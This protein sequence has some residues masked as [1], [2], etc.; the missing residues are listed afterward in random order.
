MELRVNQDSK[1]PAAANEEVGFPLELRILEELT[2]FVMESGLASSNASN[3][4]IE[5]AATKAN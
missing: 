1:T 5:K 2:E 4:R 3:A